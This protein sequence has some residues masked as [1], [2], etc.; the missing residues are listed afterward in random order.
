MQ[1]GVRAS[2]LHAAAVRLSQPLP[3]AVLGQPQQRRPAHHR[4]DPGPQGQ[5]MRSIVA[6]KII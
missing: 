3:G 5:G 6:A 4:A 2:Q 1:R